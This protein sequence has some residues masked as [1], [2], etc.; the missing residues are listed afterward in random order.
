MEDGKKIQIPCNKKSN[1]SNTNPQ[2]KGRKINR[3]RTAEEFRA[4]EEF[5]FH[6]N[7][8]S[9]IKIFRIIKILM[10]IFKFFL[11]VVIVVIL[12]AF[13]THIFISNLAFYQRR[14]LIT[15]YF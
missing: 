4:D 10:K 1:Q 3:V 2:G 14:K 12:V 5:I 6:R 9:K 8:W 7:V 15:E 11:K 13:L